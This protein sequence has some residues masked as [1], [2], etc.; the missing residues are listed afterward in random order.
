[1]TITLDP[2]HGTASDPKAWSVIAFMVK[3]SLVRIRR[4][5]AA[6]LPS[7]AMPIFQLI[8]FGGA[9]AGALAYAQINHALD[10]Y[11]PLAC[12]QGAAFGAMG[13]A[14]ATVNDLQTG[15][16]DRLRMAPA[17]RSAMVFGPL[18]A[19]MV[20]AIIPL[21]L[22]S[23]V[24][25]I[26]GAALPGGVLG[27]VTLA[28]AG[29]GLAYCASGLGLGLAFRMRSL[30]AATLTQFAI[31]FTLFLSTAQMPLDFIEGWVKPLARINP[32]TNVL[33]L[34][35]QGFLGEVTWRGTWGGLLALGVLGVLSTV[36]AVRGLR[37]FDK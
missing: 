35:R 14:F 29:M 25:F 33:R 28:I 15:F 27:L 8:A 3:R 7:L 23:A 1:V 2:S 24:A 6:F 32:M 5:P 26:G 36:F 20:R 19:S 11:A 10:W 12:M 9:F 22:V 34:A 4:I 18:C 30:A 17:G 31:F 21:V 37:S 13:L 16:F